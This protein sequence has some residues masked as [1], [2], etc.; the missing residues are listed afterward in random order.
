M[1]ILRNMRISS[2]S[3]KENFPYWI[4]II[5][6]FLLFIFGTTIEGLTWFSLGLL[7]FFIEFIGII[8][9]RE[10][11]HIEFLITRYIL[12]NLLILL[13]LEGLYTFLLLL[14]ALIILKFFISGYFKRI[15]W[16]SRDFEYRLNKEFLS[17]SFFNLSGQISVWLPLTFLDLIGNYQ[18]VIEFRRFIQIRSLT[19]FGQNALRTKAQKEISVYLEN[20]SLL[21]IR[22]FYKVMARNIL[23]VGSLMLLSMF[24]LNIM[25][26][27][28]FQNLF[29][30]K[31]ELLIVGL[32]VCAF[33]M[34]WSYQGTFIS[35]SKRMHSLIYTVIILFSFFLLTSIIGAITNIYWLVLLAHFMFRFSLLVLLK[36]HFEKGIRLF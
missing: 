14:Y 31:S 36:I 12:F 27:S 30:I 33:E 20:S 17:Q 26:F 24:I 25:G 9:L 34:Y 2:N 32:I 29:D 7:L 28:L 4:L 8:L 5:F 16:R 6:A 15:I 11:K 10:N 19:L 18:N 1:G 3:E 21:D 13:F 23:G 22:K 35:I